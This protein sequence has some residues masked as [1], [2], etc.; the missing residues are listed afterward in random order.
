MGVKAWKRTAHASHLEKLILQ[1]GKNVEC[2]KRYQL[3]IKIISVAIDS[4][5]F[6]AFFAKIPALFTVQA[7]FAKMLAL[8]SAVSKLNEI[9]WKSVRKCEISRKSVVQKSKIES[10]RTFENSSGPS[11]RT[12]IYRNYSLGAPDV[13][14]YYLKGS[15]RTA[16]RPWK[17]HGGEIWSEKIPKASINL[18]DFSLN[19]QDRLRPDSVAFLKQK[20]SELSS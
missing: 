5:T 15:W 16:W 10:L 18:V 4:F 19:D 20:Y 13:C 7:F 3:K 12:D 14:I 11:F 9:T 1:R 6:Q 8:F 17:C 2:R